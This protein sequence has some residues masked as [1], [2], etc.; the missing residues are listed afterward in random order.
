MEAVRA[1]GGRG[2]S[3]LRARASTQDSL[4]VVFKPGTTPVALKL[5]HL[6]KYV[7]GVTNAFREHGLITPGGELVP[8]QARWTFD[9]A[10]RVA[11]VEFVVLESV[12]S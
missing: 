11:T 10:S 7:A 3:E 12:E 2:P 4:Q 5:N 8:K 1:C 6:R 9:P